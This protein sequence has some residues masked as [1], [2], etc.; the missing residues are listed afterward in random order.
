V[1]ATACTIGVF[2]G[3][4]WLDIAFSGYYDGSS[5]DTFTHVYYNNGGTFSTDWMSYLPS[6]GNRS[7]LAD[8]VD[9]DGIDDL[10]QTNHYSSSGGGY[11]QNSYIYW[12]TTDGLTADLRTGFATSGPWRPAMVKDLNKDGFKDV[13]WANYYNN[14]SYYVSSSAYFGSA[15]GFTPGTALPTYGGT[16]VEASDLDD[17]GY[18]DLVIGSYYTNSY[19]TQSSVYWGSSRGYSASSVTQLPSYGVIDL[20]IS[21]LDYDGYQDVILANYYDGSSYRT[22]SSLYMG[23]AT[24]FQSDNGYALPTNGA[25]TVLTADM[26][27]DGWRDV[28]FGGFYDGS[29]YTTD[30]YLYWGSSKGFGTDVRMVLPMSG[31]IDLVLVANPE[32]I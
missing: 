18:I 24:G 19:A 22:N 13:M 7:L 3:D 29:S 32:D 15:D 23:S 14:S 2:N 4:A 21:D 27:R 11:N 6:L 17:D 30:G 16:D 1:G 12:G 10:L 20:T 8:D 9:Q 25:R 26:D 28:V 5:Y 31:G